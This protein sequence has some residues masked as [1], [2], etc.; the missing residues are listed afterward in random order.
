MRLPGLLNLL[1]ASALLLTPAS[2]QD[3][4]QGAAQGA[5]LDA[6]RAA[7]SRASCCTPWWPPGARPSKAEAPGGLRRLGPPIRC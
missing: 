2:A 7:W 4:A 1:I 5:A 6:R 3:A